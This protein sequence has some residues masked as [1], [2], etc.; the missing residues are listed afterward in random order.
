MKQGLAF[1]GE[2]PAFLR[3]LAQT[4]ALHRLEGVGMNCGCEYTRF[5]RFRRLKPYSRLEHSL[6]A[7]RIVWHFTGD[8]IQSAATLFHDIAAPTF[9]HSV[10]FLRGDAL[11]QEA[12]ETGTAELIRESR[13]IGQILQRLEI[14]LEEV[15]DYHRYPIADNDAPRLSADRL[16]Y[17]LGNLFKFRLRSTTVLRLYYQQL[18]VSRNED[19]EQELAFKDLPAAIDFGYD[20]LRCSK[21]YVSD[22]D[23]Y[24]MQ[25]LS[26]LLG[27]ALERKILAEADLMG[28][29]KD[30]IRKL[31][32]DP[33][34]AED[35][36]RFCGLSR[37]VRE[38]EAAPPELR[39]VIPAKKRCIDPL[40]RD[41]GR[42]SAI[43]AP[44]AEALEQFREQDQSQWICAK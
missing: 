10:D 15:L 11:R 2:S 38:E 32:T 18:C 5:K 42:L 3:E 13:E 1:Y 43:C 33:V 36:R 41:K 34:C 9:S 17:T 25:M 24:A 35:W 37:M 6:G 29:E 31:R 26:E 20:A 39:R 30:L 19:G 21:I 44:F 4:P 22:E 28:T 7:A 14:P 8:R 40:I 23:R 12:T 27:R 16:E